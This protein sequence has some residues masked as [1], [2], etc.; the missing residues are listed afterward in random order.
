[1]T[2]LL[3]R[4]NGCHG[5]DGQDACNTAMLV[6]ASWHDGMV[7]GSLPTLAWAARQATYDS[8]FQIAAVGL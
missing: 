4:H 6:V 2:R 7:N 8:A 5:Q 1:M 3:H